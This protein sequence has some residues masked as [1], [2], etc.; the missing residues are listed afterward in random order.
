MKTKSPE[1]PIDCFNSAFFS[2]LF[3]TYGKAR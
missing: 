3:V 1:E 2:R